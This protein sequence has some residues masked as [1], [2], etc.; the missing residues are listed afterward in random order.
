MNLAKS[1]EDIV[2]LRIPEV[3]PHNK[4][5][6]YSKVNTSQGSI[7]A[8]GMSAEYIAE[9]FNAVASCPEL[10]GSIFESE[11]INQHGI[12]LV[13]IYQEHNWRY[14]IV[15]D[16]IPCLKRKAK[17]RREEKYSPAFINIAQIAGEPVCI[18]PF[19]LEKAYANYYNCYE[20][21]NFGNTLDF[22]AEITGT[23]YS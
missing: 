14:V 7:V 13:K 1:Q 17:M 9:C 22:L 18:W 11:C 16:L 5:S 4:L 2:W 19:L 23:S 10:L 21:L 12:Y 8:G 3:F 6:V 20:N 15:D